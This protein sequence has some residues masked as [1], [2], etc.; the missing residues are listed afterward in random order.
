MKPKLI[1][2]LA[3]VLGG[4]FQS[5]AQPITMQLKPA[6]IRSLPDY[7]QPGIL[8]DGHMVTEWPVK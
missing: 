7:S 4:A 5:I 2:G 3:L 6:T 8:T 1:L